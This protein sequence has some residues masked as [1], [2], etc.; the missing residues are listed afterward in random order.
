[1]NYVRKT[2][3][4]LLTAAL[5]AGM[6]LMTP[7]VAS[8]AAVSSWSG[9][10]SE[11]AAAATVTVS[12]TQDV[13]AG[14]ND[15]CIVIASGKNVT[16]DLCGH[17]L[18]RGLTA[19]KEGGCVI[20]VKSG[21]TLTVRDS[22]GSGAGSITGGYAKNGGGI[23]NGG[24]LRIESGAVTEN[25]AS[26]QGGGVY[27]S[28][29]L[30]MA[31]GAIRENAGANGGGIYNAEGGTVTLSGTALIST[32]KTTKESGGNIAD[33]GMLTV[34]DRAEISDGFAYTEG[35]GVWIGANAVCTLTG[36]TITG[37]N[38][39]RSG[40]G[41]F[42]A[43]TL[44]VQGAVS[45]TGNTGDDVF[46]PDGKVI[47]VT[48]SLAS[49]A[50]IGVTAQS[51]RA[52]I[53]GG[54]GTYNSAQPS[55][56]FYENGSGVSPVSLVNGEAKLA[57]EGL[58]YV[59]RYWDADAAM[60]KR[61]IGH[62]ADYTV[63]TGALTTLENGR[64]YAVTGNVT[65]NNRLQVSGEAN[66]LLC[67]G[68]KLSADKGIRISSRNA[69]NIYA[70][71]EGSGQLYAKTNH[72]DNAG[73]G[74]DN[75]E[76]LGALN[77]YGG[78]LDVLGYDSSNKTSASGIGG[79]KN[80]GCGHITIFG[81]KIRASGL[82]GIGNGKS[83][84]YTDENHIVIY[85]GEIKAYC[86]A[87]TAGS[88]AAIG[89]GHNSENGPIDILGGRI[90]AWGRNGAGI[91]AGKEKSQRGAINIA[92]CNVYAESTYAAAI[93]GGQSGNGG[94]INITN[95][96]VEAVC[97][98]DSQASI[99]G[100]YGA[101]IGGGKG[102]KSGT[103]TIRS[104]FVGGSSN[105]G[106][107][108]GG[109]DGGAA[110]TILIE[111]SC[112]VSRGC[113]GGAGIGGGDG[114]NGGSI[115]IRR[116]NVISLS[117]NE[118]SDYN[119]FNYFQKAIYNATVTAMMSYDYGT[120]AFYT[121][122]SVL[123]RFMVWLFA[124]NHS[125]AAIGG[126]DSGDS[127]TILIEDSCVEV[128][129]GNY[130]SGIGGGDDGGC[131]DL[132]IRNS[133][134]IANS[135]KY[136]AAIGSGDEASRNGT[137]RIEHS[138]VTANAGAE[139][140]GIGGGNEVS[141]GN[142]II[143]DSTVTAT[144]GSYAAGI[145]GGDDGNGGTITITDSTVTATGGKDGAGIGGGED[146]SGGTITITSSQ[147]TAEGKRGGAGIGTGESG[148]T[149]EILIY[150]DSTVEATAGDGDAV[151]IGRG[152]FFFSSAV[153]SLYFA[154][155]LTADAGSS[156][157]STSHFI[158]NARY[159][160]VSSNRYA[161]LT[162]CPHNNAT[163][164]CSNSVSHV[165]KCTDCGSALAVFEDHIWNANE[166]CTVCGVS[167]QHS[168]VTLIEQNAQGE[169]RREIDALRH[170]T[171]ALP[172]CENVPDGMAFVAWAQSANY[173]VPG[174]SVEVDQTILEAV[175]LPVAETTYIDAEGVA[176]TETAK[177]LNDS[178]IACLTAGWYVVD[179]DLTMTIPLAF[180]GKVNLILAD[181]KTLTL[182][183]DTTPA[184]TAY[185][186]QSLITVYGQTAQ[187]GKLNCANKR[188][189]VYHLTQVGGKIENISQ[190]SATGSFAVKNGE[191]K[192]STVSAGEGMT[193]S[194]GNAEIATFISRTP[195]TL[196]W[197]Q[198]TDTIKFN[199]VSLIQSGSIAI[200]EGQALT[201]GTNVYTGTLTSSQVSAVRN[202]TLTPYAL[203]HFGDPEWSWSDNYQHATALF[204]CTDENCD[205]EDE[206]EAVVTSEEQTDSF[207]YTATAPFNGA[208]YQDVQTVPKHRHDLQF[209]DA[210][211]P[212]AEVRDANGEIENGHTAYWYCADCGRYFAD[213][214]GTEE[215]AL[216]DTVLPYCS[217]HDNGE[218]V[219][220]VKYYGGDA[221]VTVPDTVP[222]NYPDETVRGKTVTSIN[223]YAFENTAVTAVTIG[224][225]VQMI[226]W[227]AFNGCSQLQEVF[228][229]AGLNY[230]YS[231][232]FNNCPAL[233]RFTSTT[234]Q[235]FT[236]GKYYNPFTNGTDQVTVYGYHTTSLR[237]K[238]GSAVP[239]IGLD[240]H[241]EPT[242]HWAEDGSS[243]QATFD[244]NGCTY[245]ATVAAEE[246]TAVY[247][248]DQTVY[249]ASVTVGDVSYTDTLTVDVPLC[250]G[251]SLTL[252]GD[253]GVNFYLRVPEP[254]AG[255][256]VIFTVDGVQT[257]AP[258]DLGN[259]TVEGGR[260]FYKFT[261]D[262]AAAQIDTEITGV[263]VNGETQSEAF[264]YS[265]QTYLT[266]AQQTMSDNAAFMTL[267]S[268]LA[269]YGYYANELFAYNPEFTQHD[270]FDDR[271]F[272]NVTAA[273][274]AD[275]EAQIA[276]E[277][278]GVTYVGS[279]LMLRSETA[280]KHYFTLPAG[281]T[282]DDYT[283]LLGEGDAAIRLTPQTSGGYCFVELPDIASGH[284]G[285][286]Y[287]VT[288]LDGDGN[289]VNTWR[290]SAMSYVYK[291]LTKYAAND[292][293]VSDAL[294]A[295]VKAL[296]LYYQAA[297]AFFPQHHA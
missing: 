99:S 15:G 117:K 230:M 95:S 74:G 20:E 181:G 155:A 68:V 180:R 115:T 88:G 250:A 237:N 249:T 149:A 277:A 175:Y 5:L 188:V 32:N 290:Y 83:A 139:G 45:I 13:T 100:G 142:I 11:I 153:V 126:G 76:R 255:A 94:V 284:L 6:F 132:T 143:T 215:I 44:R 234:R 133:N 102:G 110:E 73:I 129:S 118:K 89:G 52:V 254:I 81:G 295:A 259:Y 201:D 43:G 174:D 130:A 101:G 164:A 26:E 22:D 166:Q 64:W 191:F 148:D 112:V 70:Q 199:N 59:G 236:S 263:I 49:G 257:Q 265:V 8:A 119:F 47:A 152:D 28:G 183:S 146:G 219:R 281:K 106:A 2:V 127:G 268:S 58:V 160:A 10:Q 205:Y 179:Q 271:G 54:Y 208:E 246:I 260:R 287:T 30:Q 173:Y 222:M 29:T 210:V 19:E 147:V 207:V 141:G 16:L 7:F 238:V 192:A 91:G 79:G 18:S 228:V 97:Y 131:T 214:D 144:G 251:H 275:Y 241:T 248:P 204:R 226:G 114:K 38:A 154:E 286:A 42:A 120:V 267:V 40:S 274:L 161:K 80:G 217:Y 78:D 92:N 225:T 21:G 252:N 279:S 242:W 288:V 163:W 229:G 291:A 128:N 202:K 269:T 124:P 184:L 256:S 86:S 171:I 104:S 294:V 187:T 111:D 136:A 245:R 212:T 223:H 4:L 96:T 162:P 123:M 273:S 41:V 140:A 186:G 57:T 77:I 195:N 35:G 63:V 220:V 239:F 56:F 289:A 66:L 221:V 178:H 87:S 27:N 51:A 82:A 84:S 209:N 90:V 193:I 197:T 218:Y 145:G 12:L 169:V 9:L 194:G 167:A 258:I 157:N 198:L 270:L 196:G 137:I 85:G 150:G 61:T 297:D 55:D 190:L 65:L 1:M 224:D 50:Q 231:E 135:G 266:E 39:D 240:R 276:N 75:G 172:D 296:T 156:L 62:C 33:C 98:E 282:L 185:T 14:E 285:T 235:T 227:H 264:T 165:R 122:G 60:S 253:I 200:A 31:G 67:S 53:T 109:G 116:S 105:K 278:G 232:A 34:A 121:A 48:G 280:I 24:T 107:G 292:P 71:S 211:L 3:S 125:G 72:E 159:D 203:H 158:G 176:Q 182:C 168:T 272:V 261:C 134:V 213:A 93:G 108:I 283:F 244:C 23:Y 293:A 206:A 247:D 151:A 216:A 25:L 189:N 177:R 69:L 17:T 113:G 37:N 103:I 36:G 233:T 262:V 170:A 46:L 138:T 243:A